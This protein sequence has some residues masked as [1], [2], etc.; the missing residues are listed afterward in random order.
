[1]RTVICRSP[2]FQIFHAIDF[3]RHG[4][5]PRPRTDA[6]SPSHGA[7]KKRPVRQPWSGLIGGSTPS[8]RRNFFRK[9]SEA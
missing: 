3:L 9:L 8:A 2:S 7:Q 4:K 5:S 6:R 1:M